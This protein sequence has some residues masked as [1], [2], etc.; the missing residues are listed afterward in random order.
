MMLPPSP[1]NGVK[2]F[3]DERP[4]LVRV[5]KSYAWHDER[6]RCNHDDN[7]TVLPSSLVDSRCCV[8][9]FF[10]GMYYCP[11][12]GCAVCP[13][14][15]TLVPFSDLEHHV[16]FDHVVASKV[17]GFLVPDLLKHVHR[18]FSIP[19][20]QSQE[21][22]TSFLTLNPPSSPIPGL[23]PP[24]KC[25]QCLNC[26]G[27]FKLSPGKDVAANLRRHWQPLALNPK[28]TDPYRDC[29]D[30][31]AKHSADIQSPKN[32]P[33][34][35][36]TK[37]FHSTDS[38]ALCQIPFAEDYHPAL[39]KPEDPKGSLTSSPKKKAK[40]MKSPKFIVDFGW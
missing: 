22:I 23:A 20:N 8:L 40:L 28:K 2:Y 13:Y 6:H 18:R 4:Y 15:G 38:L 3:A 25:L 31:Y 35:Y 21:N 7:T 33:Q 32:N 36:T 11:V 24:T 16:I 12:L 39:E 29:R 14:H 9:S 37:F 34:R 27:W 19:V 26:S 17:A 10:D 5:N 1:F 30:W